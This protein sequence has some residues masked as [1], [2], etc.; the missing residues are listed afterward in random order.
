MI[1]SD[2]FVSHIWGI[3]LSCTTQ[4]IGWAQTSF[5]GFDPLHHAITKDLPTLLV[6]KTYELG[7]IPASCLWQ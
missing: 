1:P 7:V 2:D 6:R 3:D 4:P 5:E